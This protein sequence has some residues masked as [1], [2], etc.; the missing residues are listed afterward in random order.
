VAAATTLM[1]LGYTT[2]SMVGP[3]LGGLAVDA[4]PLT[5]VPWVFGGLAALGWITT[6][7]RK[8]G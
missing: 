5:G 3:V 2:G 7:R 1:V 4:S 8:S 6:F